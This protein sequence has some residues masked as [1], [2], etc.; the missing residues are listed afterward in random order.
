VIE[1]RHSVGGDLRHEEIQRGQ[2]PSGVAPV[3]LASADAAEM[4]GCGSVELAYTVEGDAEEWLLLRHLR[5]R[6]FGAISHN[7]RAFSMSVSLAG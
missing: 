7:L 1:N 6:V 2:T 5:R 3:K 4:R